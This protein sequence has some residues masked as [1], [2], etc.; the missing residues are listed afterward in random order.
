[1]LLRIFDAFGFRV[2]SIRSSH[3]KLRRALSDGQRQTLTVAH[4]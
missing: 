4:T 3:A 1:M 2:V